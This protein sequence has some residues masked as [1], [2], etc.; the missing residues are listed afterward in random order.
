MK[1]RTI[2]ILAV[3]GALVLSVAVVQSQQG[4]WGSEADGGL[5]GPGDWDGPGS[6]DAEAGGEHGMGQW[7]GGGPGSW[8]GRGPGRGMRGMNMAEALHL[9]DEQQGQIKSIHR[10]AVK[11]VARKRADIRVAQVDLHALM[12]DSQ[13]RNKIHDQIQAIAAL[14]AE[15][16]IIQVDRRLDVLA[17]LGAEQQELFRKMH[18]GRGGRGHGPERGMGRGEHKRGRR[19]RMMEGNPH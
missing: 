19:W 3:V 6:W 10:A 1:R 8:R 14:K 7:D 2:T 13:D 9:T 12:D 18:R 4:D 16:R 11:K 17:Q 5:D 15:L